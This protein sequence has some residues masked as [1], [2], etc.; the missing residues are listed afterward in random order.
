M[1][2]V[3]GAELRGPEGSGL[4]EGRPQQGKGWGGRGVLP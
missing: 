2:Q 4:E 1:E 3:E